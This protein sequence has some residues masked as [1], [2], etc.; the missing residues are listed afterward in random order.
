[1]KCYT[2][3]IKYSKLDE[4]K[5]TVYILLWKGMC[6][7]YGKGCVLAMERDVYMP[8]PNKPVYITVIHV[9]TSLLYWTVITSCV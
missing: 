1:M 4:N 8:V 3:D 2:A 6:T 7:C 5:N 9:Y